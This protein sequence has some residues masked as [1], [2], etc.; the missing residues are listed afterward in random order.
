MTK[1]LD[2]N[3]NR[4]NE[5]RERIPIQ[6]MPGNQAGDIIKTSSKIKRRFKANKAIILYRYKTINYQ[7]QNYHKRI[8]LLDGPNKEKIVSD[9]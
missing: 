8:Q 1:L 9:M 2:E 3:Y 6:G 4:K 5:N 7:Y